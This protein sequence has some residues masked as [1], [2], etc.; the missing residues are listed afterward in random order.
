MEYKNQPLIFVAEEQD[1]TRLGF[2]AT[3]QA[4]SAAF[5]QSPRKI[6]THGID[7][8]CA[9]Q[10]IDTYITNNNNQISTINTSITTINSRL[11]NL[12]SAD[13]GIKDRLTALE[14]LM[15]RIFPTTDY[16]DN[17]RA[18]FIDQIYNAISILDSKIDSVITTINQHLSDI[19]FWYTYED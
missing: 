9:S 3:Q 7:F 4:K 5:I 11:D 10:N 14:T 15:N 19:D 13:N 12:V 17:G 8:Y 6:T 18:D 1:Y 2:N 16:D